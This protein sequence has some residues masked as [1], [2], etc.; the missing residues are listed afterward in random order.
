MTRLAPAPWSLRGTG[1]I[2][3][4]RFSV[5]FV[6][7][8]AT[9]CDPL[10]KAFSGGL[11]ALMIVDYHHSDVGPYQE[12]LFIPGRF[13]FDGRGY[14]HIPQIYV[15]SQD[16]VENGR[17]NW[18][19]PKRQAD[20][21]FRSDDGRDVIEIKKGLEAVGRCEFK[22]YWGRLPFTTELLPKAL[23]RLIQ[24]RLSGE[25]WLETVLSG[26][27]WLQPMKVESLEFNS[28]LFAPIRSDQI[29]FAMKVPKFNLRFPVAQSRQLREEGPSGSHPLA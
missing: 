27:G 12:L 10:D 24:Q 22:P 29:W 9:V 25:G 6:Q 19:I 4:G 23:R 7:R 13:K 14:F 8:Y 11:G 18:G 16:S 21:S 28:D 2:L 1:Y 17:E 26:S 5:D 15:S 20:F 3:I